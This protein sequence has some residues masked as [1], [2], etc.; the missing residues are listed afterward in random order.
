MAEQMTLEELKKE[1]AFGVAYV[2]DY[3][4][5]LDLITRVEEVVKAMRASQL[6]E[7]TPDLWADKLEGKI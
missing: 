2:W 3:Q 5:A 7:D 4:A 1:V 6:G